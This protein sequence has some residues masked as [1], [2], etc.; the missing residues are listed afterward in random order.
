MIL[1]QASFDSNIIKKMNK[2]ISTKLSSFSLI[3]SETSSYLIIHWTVHEIKAARSTTCMVV[4]LSSNCRSNIFFSF[5]LTFSNED[6]L[7]NSNKLRKS[8]IIS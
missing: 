7:T 1:N 6:P 5:F 3:S 8:F 2:K 4:S